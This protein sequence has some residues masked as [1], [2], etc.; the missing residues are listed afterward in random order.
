MFTYLKDKIYAAW[1]YSR[2][3]FINVASAVVM[4]LAALMPT[5][6]GMDWASVLSPTAAFIITAVINVVNVLLRFDTDDAPGQKDA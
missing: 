6:L 2:T 5:L 3:I 1:R 4:G